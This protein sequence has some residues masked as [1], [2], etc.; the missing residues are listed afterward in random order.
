MLFTADKYKLNDE[1]L[2]L[3]P[4]YTLVQDFSWLLMQW[5]T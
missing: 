4:V 5:P 1:T 3:E 2:G